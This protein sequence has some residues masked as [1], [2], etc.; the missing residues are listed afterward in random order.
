MWRDLANCA[1]IA[2]SHTKLRHAMPAIAALLKSIRE[3]T[4]G[5]TLAELLAQ[6]PNVARRTAQRWISRLV[7]AGQITAI[8]KGR[9]R[10]YLAARTAITAASA[11]E[12]DIFPVYI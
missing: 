10:R 3:A 9:S 8:G 4:A 2:P 12:A 5:V 7:D 1:I 11:T 6:H